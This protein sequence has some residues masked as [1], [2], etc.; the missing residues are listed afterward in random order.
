MLI[1][2]NFLSGHRRDSIANPGTQS[3]MVHF[4][5]DAREVFEQVIDGRDVGR[6]NDVVVFVDPHNARNVDKPI[7]LGDDMAGVDH[8]RIGGVRGFD[9]FTGRVSFVERDGDNRETETTKFFLQCLPPGQVIS[10]TS[11]TCPNNQHFFLSAHR[12]HRVRDTRKVGER[13]VGS[14]A[15]L[16]LRCR[17][18]GRFAKRND[19]DGAI[20]NNRSTHKFRKRNKVD[21]I[22]RAERAAVAHRNAYIAATHASFVEV[23]SRCGFEIVDADA[24]AVEI[25]AFNALDGADL[26]T[27]KN[28]Y[29]GHRSSHAVRRW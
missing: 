20:C 10:A 2:R 28:C 27:V 14:L 4:R 9:P 16:Q 17:R 24:H 23:P 15:R 26:F 19:A 5:I 18:V 11:P 3:L 25:R 8:A 13:K 7:S 6:P 21:G 12:R 1:G 22:V 29:R